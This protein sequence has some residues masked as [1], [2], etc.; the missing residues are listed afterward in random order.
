ML[1]R[2]LGLHAQA[3]VSAAGRLA[4][5]PGGALLTVLVIGVALALPGGLRV[6]VSNADALSGSWDRAADFSAYLALGVGDERARALAKQIGER[7]DVAGVDLIPP[8]EALTEFRE[9]S[10]LG[11]AIDALEENP[12]P[13][14]LVIRPASGA[15][16]DVEALAA[17]VAA[18]DGVDLVQLDTA[19]V[20]RLRAIL[21]L[22]GRVVDIA[23]GLLGAAVVVVMGNTIRLEIQN[24]RAE[25]EV[26]KLVG[27]T[28]GFIRRPFLYLGLWYGVLGGLAALL[29]IVLTLA[30]LGDPVR[31]LAGLYGSDYRL[32][33]LSA[34]EAAALIGGGAVL[35]WAG[36]WVATARHLRAIE[37]K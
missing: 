19:W 26:T 5:Q 35:G 33:G 4:R 30:L 21:A 27:G 31:E 13:Y 32:T 25:I 16:G 12:L 37:P 9:H 11:A 7:D 36:A 17:A 6:L 18:L 28:D 24:R 10:G 3:L 15:A 14:T 8:D 1:K 20:E 23:T 2:Y 22:A 29:V 34:A